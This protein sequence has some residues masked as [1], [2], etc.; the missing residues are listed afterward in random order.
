MVTFR[1]LNRPVYYLGL[2]GSQLVVAFVVGYVIWSVADWRGLVPYAV[3]LGLFVS[4]QGRFVKR[5]QYDFLQSWWVSL[6]SPKTL[7]D[8]KRVLTKI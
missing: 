8:K 6:F 2:T 3:T 1:H 4:V 5:K 7:A